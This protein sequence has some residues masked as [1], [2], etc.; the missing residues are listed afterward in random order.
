MLF[1]KLPARFAPAVMPFVLSILTTRVV[2]TISTLCS[3]GAGTAFVSASPLASLLSWLVAFPTLLAVLPLARR[4]VALV[5]APS[6]PPAR[7]WPD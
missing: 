3:F 7:G 2:S 5:V 4:I 6:R 1:R